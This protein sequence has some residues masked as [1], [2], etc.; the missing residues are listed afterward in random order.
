MKRYDYIKS[1]ENFDDNWRH[2][3]E[4]ILFSDKIKEFLEEIKGEHKV[5]SKKTIQYISINIVGDDDENINCTM[6]TYYVSKYN[7]YF[8]Y[9]NRDTYIKNIYDYLM[10]RF[11]LKMSV[12]N[13]DLLKDFVD[14]DISKEDFEIFADTERFGL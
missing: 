7:C 4:V 13:I 1:F 12:F 8:S 2:R 9:D 10:D 6:F 3:T 11:F 5:V 14:I